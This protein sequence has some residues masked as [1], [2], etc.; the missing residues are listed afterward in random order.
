MVAAAP[1]VPASA[2][3]RKGFVSPAGREVEVIVDLDDFEGV[4]AYSGERFAYLLGDPVW[5]HVVIRPE[6]AA[7]KPPKIAHPS[8]FADGLGVR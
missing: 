8:Y 7:K 1:W 4:D 2:F 6:M 5:K 3:I